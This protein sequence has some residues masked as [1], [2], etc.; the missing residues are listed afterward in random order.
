MWD[1]L[2]LP[3]MLSIMSGNWA[4]FQRIHPVL[5]AYVS[6]DLLKG[7]V[8]NPKV[9]HLVDQIMSSIT[10]TFQEGSLPQVC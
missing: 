4:P 1:T 9:E 3:E 10:D 8:S 6:Q 5:K 7:D 2:T